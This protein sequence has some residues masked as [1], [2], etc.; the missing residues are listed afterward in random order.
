MPYGFCY[1]TF[2]DTGMY[3]ETINGVFI[4]NGKGQV[5]I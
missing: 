4:L 2:V 1:K 3:H 5:L